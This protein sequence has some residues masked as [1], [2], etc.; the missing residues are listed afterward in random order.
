MISEFVQVSI[1][2]AHEYVLLGKTE[3][4]ANVY[5][6]ASN[7]VKTFKVSDETRVL[8]YLRYAELLGTTGNILKR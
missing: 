5:N 8:F 4:A 7:V 6:R 3:R 2:L 1:D